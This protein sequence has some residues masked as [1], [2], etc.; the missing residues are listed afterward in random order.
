MFEAAAFLWIILIIAAI[1][2][3]SIFFYYVPFVL[4]INAKASGVSISLLQLFLM[5]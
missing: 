1:I 4:W 3:L 2:L 5:R